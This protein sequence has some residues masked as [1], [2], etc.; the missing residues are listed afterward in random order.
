PER[1]VPSAGSVGDQILQKLDGLGLNYDTAKTIDGLHAQY[2]TKFF[3]ESESS[4]ETSTR[5]YYQHRELLNTGQNF[6]P[7]KM[8][9]SSYDNNMEDWTLSN[10][11]DIKKVRARPFFAGQFIW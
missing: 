4:A 9:L 1:R 6:T 11:Y 8:E 7:G 3:F 10:E 2:P 5:G